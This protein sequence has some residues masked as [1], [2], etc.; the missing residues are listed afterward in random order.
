MRKAIAIL[1]LLAGSLSASADDDSADRDAINRT[2][3][4]IYLP[5]VRANPARM[6]ELVTADFEGSFE[7]IPTRA[8]WSESHGSPFRLHF[9]RFLAPE[10]AIAEGETMHSTTPAPWVMVLKKDGDNWR[11]LL[12][13]MFA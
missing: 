7:A 9:C 12:L 6:A 13:R 3:A 11:I 4:A 8:I 5:Q 10:F 1:F 2:I